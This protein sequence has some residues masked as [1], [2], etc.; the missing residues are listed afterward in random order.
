VS[1]V[2]IPAGDARTE[3]RK[4]AA[5]GMLIALGSWAMLF[6][7]FFFAWAALRLRAPEWPP[8]GTPRLPVAL[9]AFNTAV[10]LA[11]GLV[12]RAGLKARTAGG[13]AR[14]LLGTLAL[15]ALFLGLQLA[16][17]IPLWRSGFTASSGVAGS[18]FYALTALHAL[19]VAGGIVALGTLLLIAGRPA[20]QGRGRVSAM[21][22]DF[23]AAVWLLIFLAVYVA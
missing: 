9:P 17:W 20:F 23:M 2:P 4:T 12:L 10:L 21:Y 16:V 3:A 18:I 14:G 7:S 19:H 15:G 8:A 5:V 6:A 22:W 13:R 1:A 11:S